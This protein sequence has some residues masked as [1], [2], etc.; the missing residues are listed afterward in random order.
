MTQLIKVLLVGAIGGVTFAA[1][2]LWLVQLA[3]TPSFY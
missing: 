3:L 2:F 1:F